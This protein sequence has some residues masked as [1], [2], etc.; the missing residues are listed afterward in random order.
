MIQRRNRSKKR[1]RLLYLQ[2]LP[3]LCNEQEF[4]EKKVPTYY[5][6]YLVKKVESTF[7]KVHYPKGG[8]GNLLIKCLTV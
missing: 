6:N 2:F 1:R 4:G 8:G 7:T 5:E 3:F